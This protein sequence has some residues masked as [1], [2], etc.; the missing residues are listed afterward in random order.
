M[1]FDVAGKAN[2]AITD[3]LYGAPLCALSK[4]DGSIRPKS[5]GNT[6]RRLV[7]KLGCAH[8]RDSIGEFLHPK[9]LGFETKG[10]CEA[11]VHCCRTFIHQNTDTPEVLLKID[12]RK[13]FNTVERDEI[14]SP[15][16]AAIEIINAI[17]RSIEVAFES[18]SNISFGEQ[19]WCIASLPIKFGGLGLRK[20]SDIMLPAFLAFVNSVLGLITLMLQNI[21]DETWRFPRHASINDLIKRALQTITVPPLLE[22]S[23]ICRDDGKRPDRM[24]LIPWTNGKTLVWDATCTDTLASSHLEILTKTAGQVAENAAI[25]KCNK[26]KTIVDQNYQFLAFVAKTLGLWSNSARSFVNKLGHR[27]M[28]ATGDARSKQFVIE[29][30]SLAIQRGNPASVMETFPPSAAME[31]IFLL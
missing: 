23:I 1:Q 29:R 26:Y 14:T 3:I 13:V 21:T 15:A 5:V 6:F 4:K 22:P 30:I 19:Q 10:G 8:Y 17:D 25:R 24:T 7:A 2:H 12:F 9:Q 20:A 31:E 28:V 18:I 16:W 27:M 11:A